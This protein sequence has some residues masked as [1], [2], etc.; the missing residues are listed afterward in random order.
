M[1][2]VLFSLFAAAV[3]AFAPASPVVHRVTSTR[4]AVTMNG[5][6]GLVAD[7]EKLNPL[8]KFYDPLG[9]ADAEFWGLSN[10]QTI[11]FIRESE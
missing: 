1:K 6:A 10:E 4:A 7:A 5:K 3:S 2:L 11:G 9:L 8:V